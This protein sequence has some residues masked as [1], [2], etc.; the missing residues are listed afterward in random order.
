MHVS[1]PSWSVLKQA[2][3]V[4]RVCDKD[5]PVVTIK[6]ILTIILSEH[7]FYLIPRKKKKKEIDKRK[8]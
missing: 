1:D 5:F 7:L 3:V 4:L 6:T 2:Y 8:S